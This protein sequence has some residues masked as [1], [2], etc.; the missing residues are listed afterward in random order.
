MPRPAPLP[1]VRASTFDRVDPAPTSTSP[2]TALSVG[3]G[4]PPVSTGAPVAPPAPVPIV[5]DGAEGGSIFADASSTVAPAAAP[6]AAGS[7]AVP[8]VPGEAG[9]R[10]RPRRLLAV[11]A[12]AILAGLGAVGFLLLRPTGPQSYAVGDYVGLPVD[13]VNN[14]VGG[15]GW[16]VDTDEQFDETLERGVVVRQ[17]PAPGA[18]M[19]EGQTLTLWLSK[20]PALRTLPEVTG[21]A[22]AD[23]EAAIT[24]AG[25]VAKVVGDAHDEVAPAGQVLSWSVPEHPEYQAGQEVTKGTEVHLVVSKGP[26][27]RVRPSLKDLTWEQ[28]VAKLAELGL[29]AARQPDE[30]SDTVP[31]NIVNRAEPPV[32]ASL[33]RGDTVNVWISLGPQLFDVPTLTGLT[34]EEAKAAIEATGVFTPGSV[35]GPLTGT[36][37]GAAPGAGEKHP[38][39][40]RIDLTLG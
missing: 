40:T 21:T 33:A 7:S 16:T 13:Q 12:V 37:V 34:V 29:N 20:G 38:R 25:L 23:A 39:G 1:L 36:V 15:F 10:H 17:N 4:P 30:Y 8:I 18:S 24:T 22:Q 27:P 5:V 3:D 32:G 6:A 14:D 31:A 2:P 19:Q 26:A 28:A 9:P 11:L 35:T